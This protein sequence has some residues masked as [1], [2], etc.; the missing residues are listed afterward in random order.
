MADGLCDVVV[1]RNSVTVYPFKIYCVALFADGRT[2]G[3]TDTR[4]RHIQRLA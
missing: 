1:S 4:R 3:R 2:D